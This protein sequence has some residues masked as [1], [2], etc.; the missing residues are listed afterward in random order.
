LF[1]FDRQV[2]GEHMH[3]EFLHKLRDEAKFPDLESLTKQIALDVEQAK[4]WLNTHH[5]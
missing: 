4:H 1:D 5:G 2:Y 3:V